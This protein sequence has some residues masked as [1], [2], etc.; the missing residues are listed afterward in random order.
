MDYLTTNRNAWNAR[1][2]QHV[3]S[4]F[5]DVPGFLAGNSSLRSIELDEMGD[6]AGKSLL[7]LQCH[8]GLD[9]L[10]WAR[11]GA[12]AT[13]IDLA[14]EAVAAARDLAQ[15]TKLDVQFECCDVYAVPDILQTRFDRVFTSYGAIN[16]LPDLQRW[17]QVIRSMLAPGGVFYM[18][19]F[20][21][22]Y[23]ASQGEKYFSHREPDVV[24]GGTYTDTSDVIE[25][26]LC[27][28]SHPV[29]E[30]LNSLLAVGLQ[31]EY[32][33]EYPYSP[34]NCFAG[35]EERDPGCYYPVTE[36]D[37]PMI[38]SLRMRW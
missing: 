28:W 4:S 30:I 29:S 24:L 16:W 8:F 31:L 2:L 6:V 15:Q 35:L 9:T 20:H 26:E 12:Q 21:P 32:F 27:E 22:H 1:T 11:L 19:E 25:T 7:H 13:G 38:F 23:F 37:V 5:Y 3:G 17:A 14:D 10:C 36:L 18:A 33:N 34:Y